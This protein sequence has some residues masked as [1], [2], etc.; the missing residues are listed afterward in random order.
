MK[1]SFNDKLTAIFLMISLCIFTIF[2]V[3]ALFIAPGL[4]TTVSGAIELILPNIAAASLEYLRRLL[5]EHNYNKTTN[6]ILAFLVYITI[7]RPLYQSP[8][9]FLDSHNLLI[10]VRLFDIVIGI[11][12]ILLAFA[13]IS[14]KPTNIKH[15]K[16]LYYA[17]PIVGVCYTIIGLLYINKLLDFISQMLKLESWDAYSFVY[18]ATAIPFVCARLVLITVAY[19]N[20]KHNDNMSKDTINI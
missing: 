9:I 2:Y 20:Y 16:H 3:I 15:Y 5:R 6:R 12:F 14:I 13:L 10:P 8:V 17:L 19:I 11:S 18:N 7:L 1:Q 4:S